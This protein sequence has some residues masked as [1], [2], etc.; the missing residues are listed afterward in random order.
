LRDADGRSVTFA[1]FR[2]R[3]VLVNRWA[4]WCAPC[5]AE[6]PT[7]DRLQAIGFLRFFIKA[8]KN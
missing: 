8:N 4:T 5:A 6:M 2:G 3:V 7:L 1:Q